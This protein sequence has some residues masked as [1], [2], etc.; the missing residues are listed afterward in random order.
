MKIPSIIK[1]AFSFEI[2]NFKGHI[3]RLGEKDGVEWFVFSHDE[4]FEIGFPTL[5]G[6]ENGKLKETHGFESLEIID[7]FV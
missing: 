7:L 1:E 3:K 4:E 2:A 5:Y 6:L